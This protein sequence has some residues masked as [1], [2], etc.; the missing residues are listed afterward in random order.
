MS[1]LIPEFRFEAGSG[2]ERTRADGKRQLLVDGT[3]DQHSGRADDTACIHFSG[4][5]T[6]CTRKDAMTINFSGKDE[7]ISCTAPKK[8]LHRLTTR[9]VE[10]NS[11]ADRND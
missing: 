6:A 5:S 8:N 2:Q 9:T 4:L 3:G 1:K 10:P 7:M 11:G